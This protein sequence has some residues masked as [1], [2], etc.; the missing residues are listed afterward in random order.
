[1]KQCFDAFVNKSEAFDFPVAIG[2]LSSSRQ[3]CLQHI[4]LLGLV[5]FGEQVLVKQVGNAALDLVADVD[6]ECRK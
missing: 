2:E 5:T 1:V 3:N 6:K 4:I